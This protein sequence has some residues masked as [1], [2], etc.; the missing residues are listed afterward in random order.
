MKNLY[1]FIQPITTN[2]SGTNTSNAAIE[3]NNMKYDIYR[4]IS[5]RLLFPDTFSTGK[6]QYKTNIVNE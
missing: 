6:L 1:L 2:Y 3:F 4:G 5:K